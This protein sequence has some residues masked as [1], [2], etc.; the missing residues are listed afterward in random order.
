MFTTHLRIVPMLRMGGAIP[1]RPLYALV[2]LIRDSVTFDAYLMTLER[3]L[4][5]LCNVERY[6]D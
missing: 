1:L 3:S 2:A 5:S 6:D 4:I